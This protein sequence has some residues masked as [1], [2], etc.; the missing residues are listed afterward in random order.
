MILETN[1]VS[2]QR[3]LALANLKIEIPPGLEDSNRY[4]TVMVSNNHFIGNVNFTRV[5]MSY[6]KDLQPALR[7]LTFE[8]LPGE[9]V[10]VVGRTGAGKS[11]LFQLLLGLRA[12]SKGAVMIDEQDVSLIDLRYLRG[13]LNVVMQQPFI[14]Q[15]QTIRENLDPKGFHSDREL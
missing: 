3:L 14:V 1:M 2:V 5:E 13:E 15:T 4:G 8:V 9:K 10:A 11:S 7:K 6:K 12:C